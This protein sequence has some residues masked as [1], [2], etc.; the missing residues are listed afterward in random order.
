[1]SDFF[2]VTKNHS[3]EPLSVLQVE[4]VLPEVM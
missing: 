3:Q 1:M 2:K 4:H